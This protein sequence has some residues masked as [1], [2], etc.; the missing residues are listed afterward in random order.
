M[1]TSE[2]RTTH[3]AR[4]KYEDIFIIIYTTTKYT[5]THTNITPVLE[6]NIITATKSAYTYTILYIFTLFLPDANNK[7]TRDDRNKRT[8]KNAKGKLAQI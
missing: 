8:E 5:H 7:K 2:E 3:T 1:L 6:T 4:R